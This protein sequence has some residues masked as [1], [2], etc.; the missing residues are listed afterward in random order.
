M[1]RV[2]IDK[3]MSFAAFRRYLGAGSMSVEETTPLPG[4]VVDTR[5]PLVVSAK[6]PNHTTLDPRS[7]GMALLSLGTTLPYS[8]DSRD[9][10]ISVV[11]REAL[12]ELK[13]KAQRA[14]VWATDLKSGKR[15]EAS[16]TFQIPG[17]DE[18]KPETPPK[19]VTAS[20]IA[21]ATAGGSGIRRAPR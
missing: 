8:Y 21:A 14:V 13:G 10:S 9:G 4:Q 3:K 15:V 12:D 6:I 16:W 11:I 5:Q 19:E 17:T 1:K 18:V 7:V 20:V 2:V